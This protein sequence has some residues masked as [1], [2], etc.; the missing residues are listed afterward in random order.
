MCVAGYSF[1]R[2]VPRSNS[3]TRL[4]RSVALGAPTVAVSVPIRGGV[5]MKNIVIC[6]DGTSNEVK[7]KAVTNVFKIVELLDLQDPDRQRVYYDPGVGTLPAP[8]AWSGVAKRVS[9]LGG[10]ALG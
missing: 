3:S 7:A 10:L 1:I 8:G 5:S 9:V 6:L 2:S 4:P